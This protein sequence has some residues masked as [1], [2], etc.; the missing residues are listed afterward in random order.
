MP[1]TFQ[2]RVA[3]TQDIE[4]L[5]HTEASCFSVDR[6]SKRQ[7]RHHIQ[8]PLSAVLVAYNTSDEQLLGYGICLC[9]PGTRVA[10][11]Y[12][13]A[14]LP[15]ARGRGIALQLMYALEDCAV[16]QD[17]FYMRLEVA[18][19]N[20]Q[21]IG[22]YQK[23]DYRVF[24]EYPDYYQD[25]SDALRM[26]KRIKWPNDTSLHRRTPWY[27]QQTDFSCGPASLMMAIASLKP[28]FALTLEQ[29]LDIWREA[30][31]IFMT[32]G[33]GGCHPF[34]LALAARKRSFEAEIWVSSDKPLLIEGVR[35][36]H[37]K[38]VM[39]TVHYQFFNR[40]LKHNINIH[41]CLLDVEKIAYY[42]THNAAVLLLI[43]TYRLDGQK[44]PH[45]IVVTGVDENCFFIHDPDL[46]EEHQSAI[47]CQY[48]PIAKADLNKMFSFGSKKLRA[49]VVIS[50]HL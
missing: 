2:I 30:T 16:E 22:L 6:L 1:N 5:L 42:T 10:R 21:A 15:I 13:L 12:S 25:H 18:K 20:T 26:Q 43:S 40:C 50:H 29:E 35:S 45:W 9:R 27:Q 31:T 47:D 36:E 7:F 23:T 32:S 24:G 8:S 17:R 38:Q 39:T 48:I 33:H 34:G 44:A 4:A 19:T 37:K 46:D 11:L 49:A 41:Y 28:N 14:I 3:Q